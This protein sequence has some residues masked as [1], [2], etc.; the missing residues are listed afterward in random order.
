ME[1]KEKDALRARTE[2]M[3]TILEKW[4]PEIKEIQHA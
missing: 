3:I 1:G 2:T 4:L